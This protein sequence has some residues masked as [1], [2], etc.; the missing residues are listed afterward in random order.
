MKSSNRYDQSLQKDWRFA[1]S[2]NLIAKEERS[3]KAFLTLLPHFEKAIS[4]RSV[5]SLGLSN[6]LTS[7][8]KK[9]RVPKHPDC[10]NPEDTSQPR[11]QS[12]ISFL[13]TDSRSGLNRTYKKVLK[14][15]SLL[16]HKMLRMLRQRESQLS[17]SSN[18]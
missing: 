7:I 15:P 13:I 18:E 2:I 8:A 14:N 3:E 9:K 17:P 5:H 16:Y 11:C 6:R 12:R 10:W 4:T 1:R